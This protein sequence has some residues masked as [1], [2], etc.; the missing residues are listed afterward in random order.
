MHK[1]MAKFYALYGWYVYN[2]F[3]WFESSW[4]KSS[5]FPSAPFRSFVLLPR[6]AFAMC[7]PSSLHSF[8]ISFRPEFYDI[9]G[10]PI[11]R[12]YIHIYRYTLLP[13]LRIS[14]SSVYKKKRKRTTTSTHPLTLSSFRFI[15]CFIR[16]NNHTHTR[17]TYIYFIDFISLLIALQCSSFAVWSLILCYPSLYTHNIAH[18][19]NAISSRRH[20]L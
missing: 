16:L 12:L 17:L 5:S 8:S 18:T 13:Y 15:L 4:V 3:I 1:H 2:I 11:K 19:K 7:H 6:S 9:K 14:I 20:I 10:A